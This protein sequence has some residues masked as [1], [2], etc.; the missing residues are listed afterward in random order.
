MRCARFS[1]RSCGIRPCS[2]A[3]A[4]AAALSAGCASRHGQLVDFTAA[5]EVD[6]S[7]GH[8]VVAPPDEIR[9]HSPDAPEIDGARQTIRPDGTVAFRLLGETQVAGLTARQISEKIRA[10]LSRYYVDPQVVVEVS[11]PRSQFYYVFGE[12][13]APG[14]KAYTGRDT[15]LTAL[16]EARPTFLAWRSQIRVVR[17]GPTPDDRK[18]ITVD[19]E[20]VIRGGEAQ[21]NFLLQSGDVIEV[22]PTPLAW[23]GLRVRELLY[24][25]TPVVNTYTA[26]AAAVNAHNVYQ[27]E[28]GHDDAPAARTFP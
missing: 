26:P 1:F 12:V 21:A 28:F 25:I 11:R 13:G 3:L 7:A 17:P 18:V 5:H 4:F 22:P 16:A 9:V 8:Y 27:D 24:P 23:A 19:L 14:P 10:Q 15:L 20:R 6:V 2:G